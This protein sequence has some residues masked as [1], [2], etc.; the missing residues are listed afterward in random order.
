MAIED[1][2]A[3]IDAAKAAGMFTVGV[4]CDESIKNAD[5]IIKQT[6]D[7]PMKLFL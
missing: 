6:K 5:L 4:C 2:Q 7:L 1:A 3:G